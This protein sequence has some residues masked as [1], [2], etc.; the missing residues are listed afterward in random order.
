MDVLLRELALL[1]TVRAVWRVSRTAAVLLPP[2]LA[3][4]TFATVLTADIARRNC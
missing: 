2:Y 4:T 1:L 3:W